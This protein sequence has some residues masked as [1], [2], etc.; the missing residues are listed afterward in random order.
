MRPSISASR[1]SSPSAIAVC[2]AP[3][4]VDPTQWRTCHSGWVGVEID[5]AFRTRVTGRATRGSGDGAHVHRA[6]ATLAL[7][8]TGDRRRFDAPARGV[9]PVRRA[10]PRL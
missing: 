2:F 1:R 4:A 5:D 3:R 9:A 8:D 7:A 10:F 6:A